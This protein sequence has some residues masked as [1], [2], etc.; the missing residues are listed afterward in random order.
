MHM[1]SH[2]LPVA[3]TTV[4]VVMVW[5]AA[6]SLAQTYDPKYP[7]CLQVFQSFVDYYFDCTYASMPQCQ[8]S[9]SG[10]R[11]SCVVNP[12][13]VRPKARRSNRRSTPY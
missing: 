3:A 2:R 8:A 6:P 1:R 10:R 12:Y 11:A 13:Y 4:F 5:L 9:A 7:V